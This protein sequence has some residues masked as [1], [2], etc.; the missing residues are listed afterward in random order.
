M[1]AHLLD[2]HHWHGWFANRARLDRIESAV[3]FG[4]VGAGLAA[5]AFG[6]IYFDVVRL[7]AHW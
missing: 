4:L 7:F 1:A 2:K 6:A 5:C 3:V